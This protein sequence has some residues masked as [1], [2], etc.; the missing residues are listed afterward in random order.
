MSR[1]FSLFFIVFLKFFWQ[2][3][4][5]HGSGANVPLRAIFRSGILFPIRPHPHIIWCID[6]AQRTPGCYAPR[7]SLLYMSSDTQLGLQ[8][9]DHL[10]VLSIRQVYRLRVGDGKSPAE[11]KA[12]LILGDDMEMQMGIRVA[13]RAQVQLR[14]AP[15]LLDGA[16]GLSQ[17]LGKIRPLLIR[18]LAQ[19]L[20]VG[21]QSQRAAA[22]VGTGSSG[23]DRIC[24]YHR[25]S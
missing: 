12:A 11:L 1:P 16:A 25:R 5:A 14:A 21:L 19:F 24:I 10:L 2:Y 20:F 22:L 18:A 9:G 13:E 4:D 8:C 6:P 7:C 23:T 17:I 3:A 15:Q